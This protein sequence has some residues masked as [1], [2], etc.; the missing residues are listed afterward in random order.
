MAATKIKFV[1]AIIVLCFCVVFNTQAG[2]INL[3]QTRVIFSGNEKAQTITVYNHE[4]KNYL[5]QSRIY[6]DE[7]MEKSVPFMVTPPLSLLKGDSQQV[8]R[9]LKQDDNLPNDRESVFYIAVLAIPSQHDEEKVDQ[10]VANISMGFRFIVKLFYRPEG[11][12]PPLADEGC[13]LKFMRSKDGF[14]IK[15]PTQYFQTLG[16]LVIN[17]KNINLDK[18]DSMVPPMG[19]R[20]YNFKVK[21]NLAKWNII[22]DYG[23]LSPA[24]HQNI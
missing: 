18:I 6:H 8:L 20:K 19:E 21:V 12:E 14:V 7:N 5:I 2:G 17:N 15:N 16:Q 4:Q 10:S 13:K 11:I 1:I 9:I 23:G 24:C 3:G 22:N